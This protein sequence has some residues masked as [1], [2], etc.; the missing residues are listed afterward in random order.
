MYIYEDEGNINLKPKKKPK[1]INNINIKLD[2]IYINDKM[3][4]SE[5]YKDNNIVDKI[6]NLKI[7][8]DIRENKKINTKMKNNFIV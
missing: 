4:K 7:Y 2:Y 8:K 6:L 5:I 1:N 3:L